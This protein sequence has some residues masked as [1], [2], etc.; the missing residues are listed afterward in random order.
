MKKKRVESI[1]QPVKPNEPPYGGKK[2]RARVMAVSLIVDIFD[3]EGNLID[4]QKTQPEL[5]VPESEF[6]VEMCR[7]I[8]DRTDLK[9]AFACLKDEPTKP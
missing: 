7:L 3:S 6:P 5:L 4:R 2:Y 9:D 8:R 1:P